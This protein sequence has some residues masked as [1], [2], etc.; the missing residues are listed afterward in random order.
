[1]SLVQRPL[2]H[3]LGTEACSVGYTEPTGGHSRG[4]PHGR[5]HSHPLHDPVRTEGLGSGPKG[6]KGRFPGVRSVSWWGR[7]RRHRRP[8]RGK[9]WLSGLHSL[10]SR[11]RAGPYSSRQLRGGRAGSP[12]VTPSPAGT[13][14]P[15]KQADSQGASPHQPARGYLPPHPK[16]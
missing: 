10:L 13:R 1:M 14:P 15:Q 3:S 16:A 9:G 4:H 7:H 6:G 11:W 12:R 8:L 5:L 2:G